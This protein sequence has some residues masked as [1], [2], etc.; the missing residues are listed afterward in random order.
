MLNYQRVQ[1]FPRAM[2]VYWRALRHCT[3]F[4]PISWWSQLGFQ[5]LGCPRNELCTFGILLFGYERGRLWQQMSK[6]CTWKSN[7]LTHTEYISCC[8]V[9]N[10]H[11]ICH[12]CVNIPT[13]AG[14][15][16]TMSRIAGLCGDHQTGRSSVGPSQRWGFLQWQLSHQ[17][18]SRWLLSTSWDILI[19]IHGNYTTWFHGNYD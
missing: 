17:K 8:L 7:L 14:D 13:V 2:V 12:I 9:D 18:N 3:C 10:F 1:D 5:P 4:H 16:I 11:S 19:L 15:E 6:F